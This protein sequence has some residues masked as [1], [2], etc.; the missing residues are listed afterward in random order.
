MEQLSS[1]HR[2]TE[3]VRNAGAD[4][5]PTY[6]EYIQLA[7]AIATDCSEAGR[8]DFL[9][10]CSFSPKY[11]Q[12][13]ADKLFSNALKNGHNDVHIGTAFHL[14]E[15]CGVKVQSEIPHGFGTLGTQDSHSSSASHTHA[16][17]EDVSA[18]EEENLLD[19][20]PLSPLPTFDEHTHWPYPLNRIVSYG[21]SRAQYDVLLLGTVTVLG[22]SMGRHVRCAYGGKM[23]SPCLQTF[24]TALPASGKGVLSLVRL[25]VEPLHDEIRKQVDESMASYRREKAK[26][27]TLGK[28]RAKAEAPVIPPNKMFLISGNNTGTGILQNLM[29]SDGTGLICESEADTISTA[30]GSEYGHWSDTM[31]KAFDHDR[32]S[33]NRRTDREYREVKRSYLSVLLSGTPAQVK[34]LIP[35][36]ENGLFS[37][38]LFYYMPAIHKWQ[39]QFDRQDTDLETVFTGLGMQWR[40]QLKRI[41]AGGLF[42]LRLTP[43][44]KELFNNL[45]ANLFIRS[46]L[47]NGSEMASSVARLA[48]NICRIMQVVAMLRVLESDDIARSPH[49]PPDKDISGDNLKDGIITRWDMTILP[50]DFNSVLELT[51]SLYRHATHILSFLPGTEISRRS[52]ADRDALLQSMEREF[53]RSAFLLQAEA[54]G[55]KPGTASTWLKRL[56][57]H[58]M[59]ESVDGKGTY[60]KPLP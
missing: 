39:N 17:E 45:F 42:T 58:G 24:I 57:K 48:I 51:E 44:Q 43:E 54:T 47:A 25:L 32:L 36:A 35:T 38:Q 12:R 56:V 3:A 46:H 21:T 23:L 16:R 6:Q 7:F 40:E 4:I 9:T 15:L 13:A 22:A 41:T 34:P 27:E 49:L 19:S 20:S 28:E 59:I 14:A 53:T 10:L 37:R 30:I 55:I 1:L 33:Y 60:R 11:D 18:H 5:A 31:R 8:Q 2:L 50:A 52:N 26:Y 29:D